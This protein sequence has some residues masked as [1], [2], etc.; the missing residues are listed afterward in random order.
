MTVIKSLIIVCGG[1]FAREVIWLARGCASEYQ[2][3]GILDDTDSRQGQKI[4]DVPILG[5]IE[6]WVNFSG[7]WFVV[8]IGS[9]RARKT[10]VTRM[11]AQGQVQFASLVHPSVLSS[12]YVE[13]NE[14]CIIAAGCILTTQISLGRHT[15]VN[16]ACTVGHD[17]SMGDFCTLAPQ[18]AVSGNVSLGDGVEIGTGSTLLEK[19]SVGNGS[20]IGAGSLLTK[21]VQENILVVGTPARQIRTLDEF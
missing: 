21:S 5:K 7:S 18:V 20:F 16:L 15:I 1:R 4:C 13:F 9:P 8:A 6:D 17:V 12:E 3:V 19:L 10:I 2:I 14:G 11:E